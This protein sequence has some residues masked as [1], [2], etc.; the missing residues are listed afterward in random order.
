[1]SKENNYP[2]QWPKAFVAVFGTAA[3]GATAY[4]IK[5]PQVMWVMLPLLWIIGSFD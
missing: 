3:I 5:E 1:M 2:S 4:F